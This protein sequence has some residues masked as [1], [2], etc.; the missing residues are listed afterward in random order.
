M[1]TLGLAVMVSTLASSSGFTLHENLTPV[2]LCRAL[3]RIRPGDRVPVILDGIYAV[4]YLYDPE[5]KVCALDIEPMTCVEFSPGTNVPHELA[6]LHDNLENGRAAVSFRGVLHGPRVVGNEAV[7]SNSIQNNLL[8]RMAAAN[9]LRYC[10]QRFRTKLVVES[11]L[12]FESVSEEV[13]W[14]RDQGVTQANPA[15]IEIALPKYPPRAR[16]IDYE[17]SVLLWI[18]VTSGIVTDVEVQFGDPVVVDEAVKNVRTWSFSQDVTTS[19][20]V[21]YD[22]RLEHRTKDQGE[23]ASI[24]FRPPSYM[25]VTGKRINF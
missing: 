13:E 7:L 17:G 19:F 16:M 15:P 20:T 21:E 18:T 10:A 8:A 1:I 12:S 22:F 25:R 9:N 5:V 23:S 4:D 6:L 24:E 3:E 14:P 11:I 2:P